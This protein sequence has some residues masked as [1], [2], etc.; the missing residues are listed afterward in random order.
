MPE[1]T[2]LQGV[3]GIAE[4][5]KDQWTHL[6]YVNARID[7][8]DKSVDAYFWIFYT[9]AAQEVLNQSDN[10]PKESEIRK[11]CGPNADWRQMRAMAAA[12]AMKRDVLGALLTLMD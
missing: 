2:Y 6:N 12:I 11:M 5:C 8:I 1:Q 9:Q 3:Q 4:E 10:E 7:Y